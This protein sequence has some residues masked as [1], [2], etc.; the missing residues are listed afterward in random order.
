MMRRTSG[1]VE[2]ESHW[3]SHKALYL[4]LYMLMFDVC[5]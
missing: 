5:I 2:L 4:V 3:N 1:Q